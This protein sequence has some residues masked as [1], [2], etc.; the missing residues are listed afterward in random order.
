M[1]WTRSKLSYNIQFIFIEQ[2]IMQQTKL[3]QTNDIALIWGKEHGLAPYV[4]YLGTV[5]SCYISYFN[6]VLLRIQFFWDVTPCRQASVS[7]RF[8][9]EMSLYGQ[10][11]LAQHRSVVSH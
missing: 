10:E 6:R 4:L 2:Q 11:T 5:Q 7:G 9:G 1:G 3:R 8:E